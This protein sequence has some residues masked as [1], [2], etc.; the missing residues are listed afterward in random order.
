M[1]LTAANFPQADFITPGVAHATE[2]I[3]PADLVG[4]Y[5]P[6]DFCIPIGPAFNLVRGMLVYSDN[7]HSAL[8]SY[9]TN[10]PCLS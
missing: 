8:E 6:V 1:V 2:S 5:Y 4:L 7:V 9:P 3:A 10:I